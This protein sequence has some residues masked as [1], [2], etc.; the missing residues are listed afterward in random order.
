M[1]LLEAAVAVA[2]VALSSNSHADTA[3]IKASD[4]QIA[5]QSVSTRVNYTE[6][7]GGQTLDTEVGRVPGGAISVSA[8]WGP[9]NSYIAVRYSHNSGSTK[10]TG[11]YI[12]SGLPYGSVIATDG[13]KLTDYSLRLGNGLTF[14][15]PATSFYDVAMVTPFVEFGHHQWFR[16]L[17]AYSE[18]YTH[19]Y[20]G[21]G[22]LGQLSPTSK[23]VLS[24]DALVAHMFRQRVT[25]TQGIFPGGDLGSSAIYRVGLSADYAFAAGFHGNVGMGY[26]K[27]NYG[28]SAVY[29]GYFEPDSSTSYITYQAGIGYAF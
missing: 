11:S 23:L 12:G 24:A 22:I 27:F 14:D 2:C 8:L 1:R 26:T 9:E 20:V 17:S 29:N 21:V 25:S 5:I 10:Y 7:N 28:A 18:T 3:D 19:N 6:T 16:D 15:D 4:N 13:A